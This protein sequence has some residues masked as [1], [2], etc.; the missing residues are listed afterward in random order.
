MS[1]K[2]QQKTHQANADRE[3]TLRTT[4]VPNSQVLRKPSLYRG[5]HLDLRLKDTLQQIKALAGKSD[6]LSSILGTH[7]MEGEN[8]LS[9][10]V[11]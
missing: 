8:E 4:A 6:D 1:A 2:E 7:T 9:E 11:L 5:R 10:V 3:G